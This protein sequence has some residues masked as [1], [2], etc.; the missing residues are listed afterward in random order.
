[1]IADRDRPDADTATA[2]ALFVDLDGDCPPD[3][4]PDR[5]RAPGGMLSSTASWPSASSP[6]NWP[7][8]SSSS[9]PFLPTG[10][11]RQLPSKRQITIMGRAGAQLE[12]LGKLK[13][14]DIQRGMDRAALCWD[15]DKCAFNDK[16]AAGLRETRCGSQG[17]WPEASRAPNGCCKPGW[18]CVRPW[19]S[20][21]GGTKGSAAWPATW[22]AFA[23]SCATAAAR[24]RPRPM[25][26]R[27][28]RW[29]S[30]RWTGS[31]GSWKAT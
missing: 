6:T 11:C 16:I 2:E 19:M 29:S 14:V 1:M 13:V 7:R 17:P 24:S 28:S 23:A 26:R 4:A 22:L 10:T 21:A 12:R 15:S 30:A 27:W 20:M 8:R 18:G 25:P 31:R 9:P 5:A 3:E